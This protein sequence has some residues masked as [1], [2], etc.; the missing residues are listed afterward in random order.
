M[1]SKI[2]KYLFL[3]ALLG[4]V[5]SSSVTANA[6]VRQTDAGSDTNTDTAPAS[7]SIEEEIEDCMAFA[8]VESF[9]YVRSEP[10]QES[11]SVGKLYSDYAAKIVSS[12]GE[13]TEI[14]QGETTGYV[15]T[16]CI[17]IGKNL[18][19]AEEGE[20]WCSELAGIQ[21]VEYASKFIGNPYRWGGT[22]LTHGADCSGFVQTIYA[23]FGVQLPRTSGAM[24]NVG[25]AVSYEDAV[26]GDIF[27][28]D[29]HVGIYMGDGEIVNAIN[30]R[31]GIGILSA[32]YDDIITIRRVL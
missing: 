27:C 20:E 29:G 17:K 3:I 2:K 18:Q 10:A 12:D 13:W 9:V 19:D 28:Y 23:H 22:S 21:V 30:S 14:Q 4:T 5:G 25:Q 11:E 31:R 8:D 24:R 16:E 26:A 6:Q 32:T 7:V 15:Y 1:D